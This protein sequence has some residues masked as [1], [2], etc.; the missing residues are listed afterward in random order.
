MRQ[1][2]LPIAALLLGAAILLL[3]TGLQAVLLPVRAGLEGFSI[4]SIGFMGTTHAVGFI[5]GCFITPSIIRRVGHIRTLAVLSAIAAATM[6]IYPLLLNASAWILLRV[7]T[8]LSLAGLAMITESWLNEKATNTS[9]GTIFSIYMVVNLGAITL[10]TL[11]LGAADPSAFTLFSITAIALI[12]SLIPTALTTAAAPVPASRVKLDVRRLYANSPVSV[13]G[14]LAVGL[15]NGAFSALGAVFGQRLGLE[16]ADIALFMAASLLGG[17]L[18]Q[19]P[20]GRLSDRID[21]RKVILFCAVSAA[22]LGFALAVVP[23]YVTDL[24]P[25]VFIAAIAVFGFVIFPLYPIAVSHANDFSS[26]E[27]FVATSGGL[28][29]IYGIGAVIGPALG[30]LAMRQLGDG[31]LF[32]F[33]AVIHTLFAAFTLY[34][35][36]QRAAPPTAEKPGYV[37]ISR[38]STPA[39]LAMTT[40]DPIVQRTTPD[41]DPDPDTEVG[42]RPQVS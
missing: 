34:R 33:T 13:G 30:A 25:R 22:T 24:S 31:G 29:V 8:G 27:E 12:C 15:A 20:L 40:D 35:L 28:L 38:S 1:T 2:F 5:V 7:M 6:L 9:R 42:E 17:A 16:T 11:L 26:R 14:C 19:Y 36:R 21:R 4:L 3:G 18:A 41:H 37:D 23:I 10:G 32:V 39:L